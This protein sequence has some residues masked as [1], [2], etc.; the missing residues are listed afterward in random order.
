MDIIKTFLDQSLVVWKESTGAGRLGIILLLLI[1]CGAVIGVGIWST[2]PDYITLADNLEREKATEL[3]AGLDQENITFRIK[4]AGSIIQVDKR[5]LE[6]AYI[7]AQRIGI[8]GKE[9]ELKSTYPW[10][11]PDSQADTY[12]QNLERQ[13]TNSIERYDAVES[14]TV[15][16]NIPPP[17][18]FMRTSIPPTAS[19]ILKIAR[20][21]RFRETHAATIAKMVANAVGRGLTPEQVVITDT[22]QNFYSVDESLEQMSSLEQYRTTREQQNRA[23][24]LSLLTPMFGIENAEVQVTMDFEFP[25]TTTTS[26][27]FDPDKRAVRE[28]VTETT[29]SN[30]DTSGSGGPASSTGTSGT[31]SKP[32]KSGNKSET[33]NSIY[34]VARTE[35]FDVVKNPVLKEMSIAV[36]VNTGTGKNQKEVSE[37]MKENI[38]NL[39]KQSVNFPEDTPSKFSLMFESREVFQPFDEVPKST[40]PWEQL[41]SALKILSLGIAALVALVFG[42]KTL[43]NFQPVNTTADV[44]NLLSPNRKSQVMELGELVKQN[45]EVFSKIVASWANEKQPTV[46]KSNKKTA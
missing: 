33:K 36:V 4:G 41:F 16:L 42:L 8:E 9:Q 30:G 44:T 40:F 14:A 15:H 43:K 23:K 27:E 18:P 5:K 7:V 35:K 3:I 10:M 13:L 19:V 37:T 25:N 24:I 28:E 34:E 21:K 2:L 39:I 17:Q 46:E 22:F 31:S 32:K 12:R 11:D 38:E 20:G 1:A 45:P 26:V 6:Q 29:T